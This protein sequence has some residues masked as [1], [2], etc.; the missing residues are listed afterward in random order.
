MA[1]YFD[2]VLNDASNIVRI[3]ENGNTVGES[4]LIEPDGGVKVQSIWDDDRLINRWPGP[5]A[6][7]D[8]HRKGK[9]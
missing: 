9:P 5:S 6:P 8:K 7:G 1:Q 4:L 2:D 3:Q